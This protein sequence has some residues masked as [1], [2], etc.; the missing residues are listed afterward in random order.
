MYNEKLNVIKTIYNKDG[1]MI[2]TQKNIGTFCYIGSVR[3][4]LDS[5]IITGEK[6][7]EI[8]PL[9]K[10]VYERAFKIG[11]TD[12]Y[13]DGYHKGQADLQK[14]LRELLGTGKEDK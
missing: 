8:A 4:E 2:K 6:A 10:M 7:Q 11:K 14:G 1:V 13:K 5:K 12:G 3:I 9:L